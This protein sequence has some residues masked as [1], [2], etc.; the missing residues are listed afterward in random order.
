MLSV[1][2][3]NSHELGHITL[4]DDFQCDV[5]WFQDYLA[6][7]NGVYMMQPLPP[8]SHAI[9]AD[10]CPIGGG[11]IF[12]GN[13]YFTRFPESVMSEPLSICHKEMINCLISLKLWA[14]LMPHSAVTLYCDNKVTVDV[15]TSARSRDPFLLK[16]ARE[17][18]LISAKHN[19]YILPAHKPGKAIEQTGADALSRYYLHHSYKEASDR[20]IREQNLTVWEVDP[21]MFILQTNL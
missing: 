7:C 1:L 14:H 13:C 19:L 4:T 18:W 16:V 2:R 3:D 12:N 21:F 6:N 20:L 8:P 10:A 15:L 9:N 11:G 17:I 5:A